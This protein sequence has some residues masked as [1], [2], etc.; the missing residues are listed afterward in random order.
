MKQ[1]KIDLELRKV[2]DSAVESSIEIDDYASLKDLYVTKKNSLKLSDRQIQTILGMDKNTL[3]PIINGQAKQI[4][5][6]NI[7]KIA[8]FIGMSVNDLVKIYIPEL[9]SKQIGEI[10][11]AREAGYIIENFDVH[12]LKKIKFFNS[13]NTVELA[14]KIKVFF[15]LDT[16]Y[17]YSN[18]EIIPL[19]SRT[20][21]S[22]SDLM[23]NFWVRSALV[24]FKE[25]SN[26]YSYNR[27][28][29]IELMPKIRPYT[30]DIRNGL[31]KVLK[32]LYS[33]GVTVIFQP[34]VE[35]IQ[36]R[37]ATM[38]FNKKPC[39]VLSDL[40][41]L[42]PT[43]WFALLHELHH[44]LYDFEEI[45]KNTYHISSKEGDLFLMDEEKADNFALEYLLNQSRLEFASGYI[46]SN[47]AIEKLSEKWCVHPS[48]VYARYCYKTNEWP[49][50]KKYIPN[51]DNA[52]KLLNTHPFEKETLIES[53]REIK[54]L[55]YDSHE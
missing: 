26:P 16:L 2:L 49:Y 14:E 50:Y 46:S 11:R 54:K 25:I 43:L 10:Q 47:Y 5:F 22:S 32:A 51:M 52:I 9:D 18:D 31:I 1:D 15:C 38:S 55:I 44:V 45:E 28:A 42:Y 48:I 39:I 41:N 34:G 33:V 4:N 24:Q 13:L 7:V 17:D 20:K 3:N 23:R 35:K 37:G 12:T 40:N 30:R 6:I 19:F 36:V 53:A 29:L 8:H 27:E 21:R